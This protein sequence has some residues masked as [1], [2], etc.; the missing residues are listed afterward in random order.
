LLAQVSPCANID[1]KLWIANFTTKEKNHKN[2]T[3]EWERRNGD[4]TTRWRDPFAFICFFSLYQ[5]AADTVRL[6][7][8]LLLEGWTCA[9]GEVI[10]D[11]WWWLL[12][13]RKWGMLCSYISKEMLLR[14][15]PDLWLTACFCKVLSTFFDSCSFVSVMPCVQLLVRST[16]PCI[17]CLIHS[18]SLLSDP[19]M[20]RSFNR[21]YP[22]AC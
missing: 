1:S 2:T 11:G 18:L 19:C 12:M 13:V 3:L 9:R 5:T 7:L 14:T 6:I 20:E 15:F 4:Q 21:V 22:S 8:L 17:E 10:R 16:V